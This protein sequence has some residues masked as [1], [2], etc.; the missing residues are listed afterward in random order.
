[1]G[2]NLNAEMVDL[3]EMVGDDSDDVVWL[4]GTIQAH[5]DAT[6]SAVGQRVLTDWE[7]ELKNF[8]KVMPRD[9]KRVLQAIAQAERTGE[10][11]DSAIMAAANA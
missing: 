1:L 10:D 9:F 2:D 8:V 4:H 3:E 7:N 5:V 11:V 6:D